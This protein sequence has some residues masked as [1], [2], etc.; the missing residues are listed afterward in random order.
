MDEK[1]AVELYRLVPGDKLTLQAKEE[2]VVVLLPFS[3]LLA[4]KW[5]IFQKSFFEICHD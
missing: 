1:K 5:Q 3:F 4:G 2:A